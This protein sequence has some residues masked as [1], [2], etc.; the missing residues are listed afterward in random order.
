MKKKLKYLNFLVESCKEY[1]GNYYL[2]KHFKVMKKVL[3]ISH[4]VASILV[5]LPL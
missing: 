4:V 5:L 3:I 1:K 2:S